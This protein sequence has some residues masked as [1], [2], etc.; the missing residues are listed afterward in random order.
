MVFKIYRLLDETHTN[1]RTVVF[2]LSFRSFS[3]LPQLTE[4]LQIGN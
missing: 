1:A 4:D 3:C 2:F